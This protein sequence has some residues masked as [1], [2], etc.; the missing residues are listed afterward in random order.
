MTAKVEEKVKD[1]EFWP[2]WAGILINGIWIVFGLWLVSVGWPILGVFTIVSSAI[3]AVIN[4][5]RAFQ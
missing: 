1:G 5:A 2:P 3:L 4:L